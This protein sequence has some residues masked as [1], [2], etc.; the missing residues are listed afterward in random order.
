VKA[1]DRRAAI[2]SVG[3]AVAALAPVA[4]RRK[5]SVSVDVDPQ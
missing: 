1:T 3:E 5:V 2:A 4:S